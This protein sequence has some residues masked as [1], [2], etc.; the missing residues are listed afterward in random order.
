MTTH[1][2]LPRILKKENVP[3]EWHHHDNILRR[4][5]IHHSRSN[6]TLE[7]FEGDVVRNSLVRLREALTREQ[8]AHEKTRNEL[9]KTRKELKKTRLL[10]KGVRT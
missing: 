1:P 8:L 9:K 4:P 5:A 6:G 7:R 3:M 2:P 10:L